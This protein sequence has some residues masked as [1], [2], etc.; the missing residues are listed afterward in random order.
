MVNTN[1]IVVYKGA[2]EKDYVLQERGSIHKNSP[3]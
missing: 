3:R 1:R 2:K